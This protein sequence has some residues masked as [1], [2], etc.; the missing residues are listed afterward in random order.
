[1]GSYQQSSLPLPWP[2]EIHYSSK[3]GIP[4][5]YNRSNGASTW[6][7]P[8]LD[9]DGR[10]EDRGT[11]DPGHNSFAPPPPANPTHPPSRHD[12]YHPPHPPQHGHHGA[13]RWLAALGPSDGPPPYPP[14]DPH[15][16]EPRHHDRDPRDIPPQFRPDDALPPQHGHGAARYS[17]PHGPYPGPER[18]WPTAAPPY[19]PER[20]PAADPAYGGAGDRQAAK[21][22]A[23]PGARAAAADLRRQTPLGDERGF[24][25]EASAPLSLRQAPAP[26]PKSLPTAL[27]PFRRRCAP[28]STR[29]RASRT[30]AVLWLDPRRSPW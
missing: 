20:W 24:C 10:A 3:T 15:G 6:K 28:A 18:P 16:A 26:Q 5:F 25:F 2:W 7:H 21:L 23:G 30:C 1:M 11:F 8:D 12:S 4:Y 29:R 19:Y 27:R 14:A 13:E 9:K 17:A 22:R